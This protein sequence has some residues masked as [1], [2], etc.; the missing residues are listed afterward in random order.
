MAVEE[1]NEETDVGVQERLLALALVIVTFSMFIAIY[2]TGI[3]DLKIK[4]DIVRRLK[5]DLEQAVEKNKTVM[6][7]LKWGKD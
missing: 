3:V 7:I 4:L 6:R 5:N 1:I 2:Q